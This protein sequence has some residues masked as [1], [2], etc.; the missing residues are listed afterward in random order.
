MRLWLCLP[1]LVPSVP[2]APVLF[3]PHHARSSHR[4]MR[5]GVSPFGRLRISCSYCSAVLHLTLPIASLSLDACL[6]L[7]DR[8]VIYRIAPR[9]P[10]PPPSEHCAAPPLLMHIR[11]SAQLPLCMAPR[12]ASLRLAKLPLPQCAAIS[13]PQAAS[14]SVPSLRSP[15]RFVRSSRRSSRVRGI[16]GGVFY[17]SERLARSVP[18]ARPRPALLLLGVLASS[19]DSYG[20]LMPASGGASPSAP[21]GSSERV[22]GSGPRSSDARRRESAVV[23]RRIPPACCTCGTFSVAAYA[24]RATSQRSRRDVAGAS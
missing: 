15:S 13:I 17:A 23:A 8:T 16:D 24:E 12:L 4:R 6:P 21:R 1:S 22:S 7:V 11:A 10:P 14:R 5:R 19:D 3:C 18:F 20:A 2:L 9:T